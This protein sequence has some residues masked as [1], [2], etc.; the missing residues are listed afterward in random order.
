MTD[1]DLHRR[2]GEQEIA[3]VLILAKT[4]E[5]SD[6]H[7]ALEDHTWV[8]LVQGGRKGVTGLIAYRSNPRVAVGYVQISKGPQSWG[9]ELLIH[10]MERRSESEVGKYLLKG[11]IEE[12]KANGGGHVHMWLPKPSP[13]LDDLAK[14]AGFTRGRDLYQMRCKLP[15]PLPLPKLPGTIRHFQ[16]GVD[17][18]R[19]LSV[20]NR[21][22]AW[23]PE[24]GGWTRE[25]LLSREQ[26]PWFDPK[27]FFLLE[28]EGDLAA[29]VWTKVH[30]DEEAPIGEIYVVA[31]NPDYAHRGIGKEICKYGLSYLSSLGITTGMLYVDSTNEPA[32][33][34]Y[35]SLGFSVDHI[36]RA[37]T[38]DL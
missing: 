24:Q 11:A 2:I 17:E 3:S 32:L 37:Y 4:I 26:E 25:T 6:G 29:F 16:V 15:L 10:P 8:D 7:K 34:L 33:C 28:L 19:W 9:I 36:D 22:F 23:H 27:G 31:T 5:R 1:L 35:R 20:N 13:Y 14:E 18:D 12:I 38:I 21:A 30:L